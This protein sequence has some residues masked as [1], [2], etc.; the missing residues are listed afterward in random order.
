[1]WW[2]SFA[3]IR[4]LCCRHTEILAKCYLKILSI[5]CKSNHQLKLRLTKFINITKLK[6]SLKS[7]KVTKL[8]SRLKSI[9]ITKLKYSVRVWN[10]SRSRSLKSR[11]VEVEIYLG[12]WFKVEVEIYQDHEVSTDKSIKITKLVLTNLSRSRS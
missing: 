11:E 1:M 12:H 4:S 8:K 7:I 9:K 3:E 2:W 6:S 5:S 10:L